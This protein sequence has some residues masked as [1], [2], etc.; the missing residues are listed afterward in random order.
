MTGKNVGNKLQSYSQTLVKSSSSSSSSDAGQNALNEKIDCEVSHWKREDCNATCGDGYRW[1][2]RVILVSMDFFY[3]CLHCSLHNQFSSALFAFYN[4][5]IH[6]TAVNHVPKECYG[7][8][9][10]K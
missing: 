9:V 5:N 10:V 4:R 3:V 2:S 8:K 7:W 6:E 1:K